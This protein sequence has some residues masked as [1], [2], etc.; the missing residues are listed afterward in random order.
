[1]IF[2]VIWYVPESRGYYGS[3]VLNLQAAEN[4]DFMAKVMINGEVFPP[5][6]VLIFLMK[7]IIAIERD[8]KYSKDGQIH[9]L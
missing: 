5:V 7:Y 1:M 8:Q 9:C 4:Q 3:G 6:Y 2:A